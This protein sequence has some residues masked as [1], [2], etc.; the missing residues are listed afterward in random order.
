MFE[1]AGFVDIEHHVQQ[2]YPGTP[3]AITT[4]ARAP[5]ADDT[6]GT[7]SQQQVSDPAAAPTTD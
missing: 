7:S 2:A 1:T 4:I 3:Q 6:V 5:T